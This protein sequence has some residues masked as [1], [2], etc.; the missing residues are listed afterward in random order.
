MNNYYNFGLTGGFPLDQNVLNDLQNGI[1]EAEGALASLL[2]PFAII[3]GC[4]NTGGIISNG[5]VAVNGVIMPFVGGPVQTYVIP[6]STP[7]DLTYFSDAVNPSLTAQYATFGTDGG[8]HVWLW[9]SFL[10]IPADGLLAWIAGVDQYWQTGDVKEIDCTESYITSNFD[11]TGLG[12]NARLGWA[13]CNGNNGTVNRMG[14]VPVQRAPAILGFETMGTT[15]GEATHTLTVDEMPSHTHPQ[16]ADAYYTVGATG[17]HAAGDSG[18]GSRGNTLSAGGDD[19]HNNLQP[20][21][22]TLFI[23]KL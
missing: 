8:E 16:G 4:V 1:L 5:V 11:S 15:G 19:A 22:V 7:T 10:T 21:I 23:Q 14:M 9:T 2:G 12:T 18:S 6:I 13:I 3:S 20:Y 17:S